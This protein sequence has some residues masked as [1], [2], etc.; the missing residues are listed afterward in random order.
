MK[1]ERT[2]LIIWAVVA[3]VLGFI[4]GLVITGQIISG[5]ATKIIKDNAS[6]NIDQKAST[7]INAKLLGD[8]REEQIERVAKVYDISA[9]VITRCINSEGKDCGSTEDSR[10]ISWGR[11]CLCEGAFYDVSDCTCPNSCSFSYNWPDQWT[12]TSA[13]KEKAYIIIGKTIF[14]F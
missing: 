14:I 6:C 5:Q 4:V 3:L 1:K 12:Y 9:E 2:K 7:I 11:S 13:C 10:D 8:T